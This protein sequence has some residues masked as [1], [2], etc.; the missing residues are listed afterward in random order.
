MSLDIHLEAVI[1]RDWTSTWRR[2]MD[3]APGAETVFHQLVNLQPWECDKVTLLLSS[4]GELADGGRLLR[5]F[6]IPI[7]NIIFIELSTAAYLKISFSPRLI[8][9]LNFSFLNNENSQSEP[10]PQ[11]VSSVDIYYGSSLNY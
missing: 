1:E 11:T 10:I 7:I 5:G 3:S 6:L 2:S 8:L 4:H 9:R